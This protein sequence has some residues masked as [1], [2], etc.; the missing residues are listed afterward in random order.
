M[1]NCSSI[2]FFPTNR[3]IVM[4]QKTICIDI[5]GTLVHFEEW[6]GEDH[7]GKVLPG[8]SDATKILHGEGWFIIIY[9]TRAN[10]DLLARFLDENNIEYDSINENPNQPDNAK[11][12]KPIADVYVDDRAICFKGDWEQTLK[13][14]FEFKPWEKVKKIGD[15]QLQHSKLLLV[16]DFQQAFYMLRHYDEVNWN[17]TKFSFG[18]I[19]VSLGACWTIFFEANKAAALPILKS[20]YMLGIFI[21]LVLSAAFTLISILG[22]CKNRTYFVKVSRYINEFRKF[23]LDNNGISFANISGMWMNPKFPKN[24]DWGS[25]QMICLYLLCGCYVL[26]IGLAAVTLDN[27]HMDVGRIVTL[28]LFVFAALILCGISVWKSLKD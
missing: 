13:E 6:Q 21:L 25:T 9:T 18:Q 7:F 27:M 1:A 2:F 28:I 24:K 16:N 11:G 23:A 12:G 8:A 17:L 20:Y 26:E 3:K 14:I 19:L 4:V 15:E 10:K 22:I 5:D